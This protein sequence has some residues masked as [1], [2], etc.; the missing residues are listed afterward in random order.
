MRRSF[1]RGLFKPWTTPF[2]HH[3]GRPWEAFIP[4]GN[5]Y[6]GQAQPGEPVRH[7]NVLYP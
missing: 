6:L 1:F 4:E 3:H 5:P 2:P 7:N